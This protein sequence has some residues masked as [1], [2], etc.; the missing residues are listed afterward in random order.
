MS[1]CIGIILTK[2]YYSAIRKEKTIEQNYFKGFQSI[3]MS[4]E[5]SLKWLLYDCTSM[6][7]LK[8]QNCSD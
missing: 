6:T 4:K 8:G 5:A 2:D 1:K 3:M 7:F